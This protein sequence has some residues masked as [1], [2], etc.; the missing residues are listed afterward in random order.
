MIALLTPITAPLLSIKGPP[1]L[2]GW[3]GVETWIVELSSS[4]P[5]SAVRPP[6]VKLPEVDK[7]FPK[8]KP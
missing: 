3:I 8:G 4:I 7:T 5:R 2:P 6:V 1:L